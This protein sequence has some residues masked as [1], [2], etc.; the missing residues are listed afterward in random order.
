MG[1]VVV[2][3]L[4]RVALIGAF[5]LV[6]AR[7]ASAAEVT[8]FGANGDMATVNTFDN[9]PLDLSVT[10]D[11]N[12]KNATTNLFFNQSICDDFGCSGIFGFGTIP[13]GDFSA[14]PGSARL[15]TNLASN[16]S[17]TA[18]S[19]V[20]DFTTGTNTQTP[21]TAGIVMIDW[22]SVP[23]NSSKQTGESTTTSNGFSTHTSGSSSF[24][25]ATATGSFFGVPIG[26]GSDSI[27]TNNSRTIV[28]SHD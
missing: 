21:I 9:P 18:F 12:G 17:F 13:N 23:H 26:V 8:H 19:F 20:F 7:A 24:V 27:G 10:R 14:G 25:R 1:A 6:G 15:N 28:I 11:D 3:G 2:K 22:K 5:A 4:S 16:P